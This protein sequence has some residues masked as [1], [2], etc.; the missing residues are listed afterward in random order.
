M[1]GSLKKGHFLVCVKPNSQARKVMT[2][3]NMCS[4]FGGFRC[5][6]LKLIMKS[7]ETFQEVDTV[8]DGGRGFVEFDRIFQIPIYRPS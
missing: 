1:Q 4:D 6:P 5:R 2:A 7:L 8:A 3:T